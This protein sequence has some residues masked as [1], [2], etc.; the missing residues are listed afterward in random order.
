[1]DA[2]WNATA[3]ASRNSGAQSTVRFEYLLAC[4]NTGNCSRN[5]LKVAIENIH[6][7]TP[8]NSRSRLGVKTYRE[9]EASKVREVLKELYV[10]H[11]KRRGLHHL[12][13]GSDQAPGGSIQEDAAFEESRAP[14]LRLDLKDVDVAS[15]NLIQAFVGKL[16]I[17]GSDRGEAGLTL[18]RVVHL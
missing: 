1:A 7:G 13:F 17:R 5:R 2:T 4:L 12:A 6:D 18:Q 16:V 8:Y 10:L 14:F 9:R 11:K 3:D 15:L